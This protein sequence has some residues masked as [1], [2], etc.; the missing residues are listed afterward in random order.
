MVSMSL[1]YERK[2]YAKMKS[3]SRGESKEW[4]WNGVDGFDEVLFKECFKNEVCKGRHVKNK[5]EW[6]CYIQEREAMRMG[7]NVEGFV[8]DDKEGDVLS[9]RVVFESKRMLPLI[10]DKKCTTC[11]ERLKQV[12]INKKK[13]RNI[14]S[15]INNS[16]GVKC[17]ITTQIYNDEQIKPKTLTNN[18]NNNRN[19]KVHY[20]KHTR[21]MYAQALFD[22]YTYPPLSSSFRTLNNPSPLINPTHNT[23]THFHAITPTTFL[24]FFHS[25]VLKTLY[26]YLFPFRARK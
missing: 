25:S 18:V 4:E 22:K 5:D 24:S 3:V 14:K 7:D 6:G 2:A 12:K 13:K 20:Y 23:I 10:E 1:I 17:I 11:N 19:K 8:G 26:S 9:G 15:N 21:P 16:D